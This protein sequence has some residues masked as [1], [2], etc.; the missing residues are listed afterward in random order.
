MEKTALLSSLPSFG[1]EYLEDKDIGVTDLGDLKVFGLM[2]CLINQADLRFI[3]HIALPIITEMG[4]ASHEII[5]DP[6]IRLVE[7]KIIEKA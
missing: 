5:Q 7:R 3:L 1:L 4:Y 6:Q 2:N